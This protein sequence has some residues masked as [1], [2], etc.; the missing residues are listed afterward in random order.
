GGM[1]S[2]ADLEYPK[3]IFH[4]MPLSHKTLFQTRA[5][6]LLAARSHYG[7][8]IPW[9]IMT[10]A[11][12][13]A[14]TRAYFTEQDYFGLGKEN[15]IF[16]K[17]E[18]APTLEAGTRTL[19]MRDA[20]TVLA[21]P[22]GNGGLYKAMRSAEARTDGGAISALE[23]ARKRGI[24]NFIYC[25]VDN[26][27]PVLSEWVLGCHIRK[28]AEFTN[29]LVQKR[30]PAENLGIMVS[31]ARTGKDFVVE[32]NQPAA[33]IIRDRE[34]FSYGT[35]SMFVLSFDFVARAVQPVYRIARGKKAML[36]KDGQKKDGLVDKFEC[37]TFDAMS[38][39]K[40]AINVGLPRE[41][42]FAPFKRMHGED[43][44]ETVKNIYSDYCKRLIRA[45]LPAIEIPATTVIELPRTAAYLSA[46][47]LKEKLSAINFSSRL[48]ERTGILIA[49]DF[50]DMTVIDMPPANAAQPSENDFPRDM[51]DTE[52]TLSLV[53]D[54][55]H[56]QLQEDRTYVFKYD[57]SLSP[58]QK[59]I[60]EAYARYLGK[61]CNAIVKTKQ[62]SR[63]NGS[64]ESL[65]NVYCENMD[66]TRI[67]EGHVDVSIPEGT[68][69]EY[70]LRIT[71]M[72]NIALASSNIP[73]ENATEDSHGQ[74]VNFI[75]NQW[76]VIAGAEPDLPSSFEDALVKIRNIV[77]ILPRA[78]KV[79]IEKIEEYNRLARETL[80]AA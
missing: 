34:G 56:A 21:A 40:A 23:E 79:T 65:I 3:G 80:V 39:A 44:P 20:N 11:H 68:L 25:Q 71:G 31:D 52:R 6:E 2:R 16:I 36:F 32:Y 60:I 18:S 48:K 70:V 63:S 33:D 37:F 4:I 62:C 74:L 78:D 38:Q 1:S 77:L 61:R 7:V 53:V 35:I 5:E 42:C 76:K 69:S 47:Q 28:T 27:M 43:S 30:D 12:T 54:R 64:R 26:P 55:I 75:R 14:A 46:D 66:G 10:S 67:G 45:A 24:R 29:V 17:Q 57:E 9:F 72:V 8:S 49:P 58:S 73:Y 41:E 50:N 22:N 15:V 13:E 59:E 51:F 19:A